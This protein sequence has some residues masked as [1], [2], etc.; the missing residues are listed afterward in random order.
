[1]SARSLAVLAVLAVVSCGDSVVPLR[2]PAADSGEGLRTGLV[3]VVDGR[4]ISAEALKTLLNET[5]LS[6]REALSR[7]QDEQLLAAEAAR[8]GYAERAETRRL[9]RQALV[10]ALLTHDVESE[11]VSEAELDAAYA[12]ARARFETPERRKA[13]HVLAYLAKDASEVQERAARAFIEQTCRQLT[14]S[15][16]PGAV[17][18]ELKLA[19][20]PGVALKI[21]DLPAVADDGQLVP[22][23]R[24]ALFSRATPGVV[25]QP[26]RTRFG[27]HCIVLQSILPP[28]RVPLADAR[29]E[30]RRDLGTQKYKQRFDSLLAS[31]R[32]RTPVRY[33]DDTAR[34]LASLEF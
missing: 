4:G 3:S 9:A 17:L 7:L 29:R 16:T 28:S 21:E 27:W 30:L 19:Q 11:P 13:S 10:Q 15:N 23:F 25:A 32:D 14:A 2:E 12:R 24:R 20:P 5:R 6:P 26:V 34:A 18:D 1:M 33:A 22:E 31:L 8:R